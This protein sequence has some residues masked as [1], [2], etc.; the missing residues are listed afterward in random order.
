MKILE[1]NS[2]NCCFNFSINDLNQPDKCGGCESKSLCDADSCFFFASSYSVARAVG[3][4]DVT[5]SSDTVFAAGSSHICSGWE[6]TLTSS[7]LFS[8]SSFSLSSASDNVD[9]NND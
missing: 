9:S 8:S 6:I 5:D 4:F 3:A 7:V 1:N 2:K